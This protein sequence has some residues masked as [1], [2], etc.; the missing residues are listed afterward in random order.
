MQEPMTVSATH[1]SFD[2]LSAPPP[3]LA[4]LLLLPSLP[5]FA[6]ARERLDAALG[7]ELARF[8]VAALSESH[9]AGP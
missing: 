4:R 1:L 3:R 6:T 2:E 5:H 9:G 8:L 7:P